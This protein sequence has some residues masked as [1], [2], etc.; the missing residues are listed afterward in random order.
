M[1]RADWIVVGGA[2]LLLPF[3]Y[4]TFWSETAPAQTVKITHRHDVPKTASLA[5]DQQLSVNGDLGNS[6]LEI[7]QGKVRFIASPCKTKVCIHS[8]WINSSG[9]ILACLPNGIL[10]ELLGGER[11]YDAINF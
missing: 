6:T 9:Q 5:T 10:V 4:T 2:A 11:K 1:T 8:G 3:L 7:K